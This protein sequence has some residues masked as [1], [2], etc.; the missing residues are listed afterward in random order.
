GN[1]LFVAG[2]VPLDPQSNLV[3]VDDPA[4]Q[5]R[6]CLTNL[7]ILLDYHNFQFKDIR[8]LV[9]YVVGGHANLQLAWGAVTS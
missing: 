2:Q 5:A 6:Q 8:K 9:V 1:Q 4:V 7:N 3:G